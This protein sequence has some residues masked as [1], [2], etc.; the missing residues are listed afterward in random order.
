MLAPARAASRTRAAALVRL[1][2]VETEQDIWMRAIFL[3]GM[4]SLNQALRYDRPVALANLMIALSEVTSVKFFDT[5]GGDE[6]PV[7][8]ILVHWLGEINRLDGDCR[9]VV[10]QRDAGLGEGLAGPMIDSPDE[11]DVVISFEHG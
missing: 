11:L 7:G 3:F 6:N 2:A 1:P 10:E 5:R 9:G 4:W 8:G